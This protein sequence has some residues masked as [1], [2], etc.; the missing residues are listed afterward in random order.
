M[1]DGLLD[2]AALARA[3]ASD[4]GTLLMRLRA[5]AAIGGKA[6]GDEADRRANRLILDALHHA[7]PA[8]CVLSEES[9]DDL[10][11]CGRERVWIVDPLDGTREYVDGRDDWAVHVALAIDG[12][13]VVGAVAQPTIGRTFAS[14]RPPPLAA[15]VQ[16]PRMVVSRTRA[17]SIAVAVAE[18]TGAVLVPMGSAGAKAMAVVRGVAEIYLHIGGQHQWDSCAPVA[19]ALAAGLHVSR[20]DGAPIRYNAPETWLPDLLICHREAATDLLEAI[21]AIGDR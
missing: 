16:P 14:D 1:T 20:I 3:I 4:A 2:D 21:A 9:A 7:R 17:P 11:R 19:V 18:R 15:A 12:V 13:A 8:D 10:V 5:K 6:L